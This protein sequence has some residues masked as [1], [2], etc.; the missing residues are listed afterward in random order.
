[1]GC[2]IHIYVEYKEASSKH[3]YP[4][5]GRFNP[6][7]S[8]ELFDKLAG[9]RGSSSPETAGR[10][11]PKDA[12]WNVEHD[13]NV[14]IDYK[15]MPNHGC[16]DNCVDSATAAR[17]VETCGSKYIEDISTKPSAVTNPD[18][19]GRSW[20]TSKEFAKVVKYG[21]AE[22]KALL[23]AVKSLERNHEVRLIFWFDN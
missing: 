16:S 11:I 13:N 7:R 5:G 22:Y 19:H 21:G 10:G 23:A 9:V 6:G 4:F 15:L 18:W 20:C 2:D 14:C 8:Y 1:M 17:W 3:W 12:S